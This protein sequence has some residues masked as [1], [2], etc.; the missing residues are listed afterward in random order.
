M[1]SLLPESERVS[2]G[3]AMDFIMPRIAALDLIIMAWGVEH[4]Y[5]YGG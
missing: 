4:M 5:R 3:P 2:L 1:A